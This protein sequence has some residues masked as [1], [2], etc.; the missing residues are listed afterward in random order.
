MVAENWT[1]RAARRS[2]LMDDLLCQQNIRR[3]GLFAVTTEGRR[4][5][6]GSESA[7]GFG[8]DDA[9]RVFSFWLG[10]DEGQQQVAFTYWGE[11]KPEP[12]W[13]ENEEYQQ[14]RRAAG[15]V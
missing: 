4:L 1:E 15:L 7:S 9:G 8:V 11:V 2:A 13:E 6:Y 14:A 5:P 12:D 10:C 3:Y